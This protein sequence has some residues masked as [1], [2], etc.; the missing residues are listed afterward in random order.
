MRP[1]ALLLAI[2]LIL[3]A[4]A[5]S[6]ALLSALYRS[7]VSVHERSQCGNESG[8]IAAYYYERNE[9]CVNRWFAS[10]PQ[11]LQRALTHEAVHAAQDCIAGQN[12]GQMTTVTAVAGVPIDAMAQ[13]LDPATL[14]M[15]RSSYPRQFWDVEIE[16]YALEHRT[17]DV[18]ELLTLACS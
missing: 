11:K 16:A 18:I 10:N 3:P 5:H 14:A 7:G 2:S 9:I 1:Q 12:N 13:T 6:G 17:S 15:I 8:N 4:P